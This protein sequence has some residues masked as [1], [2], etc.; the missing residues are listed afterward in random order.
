M[1][2]SFYVGSTNTH[3]AHNASDR[4]RI[5]DLLDGVT[6]TEDNLPELVWGFWEGEIERTAV[7]SVELASD[8][9]AQRIAYAISILT[10][11]DCVLVTRG[12]ETREEHPAFNSIRR[13]RTFRETRYSGNRTLHTPPPHFMTDPAGWVLT[14]SVTG[15]TVAYLVWQDASVTPVS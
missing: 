2:Y 1:R 5:L 4:T 13:Y 9:V 11:N 14:P 7:Y 6:G 8:A 12:V 3:S 15:N 10:G